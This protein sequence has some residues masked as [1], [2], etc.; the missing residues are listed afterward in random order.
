MSLLQD[1]LRRAQQGSGGSGGRTPLPGAGPLPSRRRDRRRLIR[2]AVIA[3]FLLA[4][5]LLYLNRGVPGVGTEKG[6]AP[7][8]PAEAVPAAPAE[9]SVPPPPAAS[10]PSRPAARLSHFPP[11]PEIP[12]AARETHPDRAAPSPPAVPPKEPISPPASEPE[13]PRPVVAE[14]EGT[15]PDAG[16]T[17]PQA[18]PDPRA[19][20]LERYNEGVRAQE[21]GEWDLAARIFGEVVDADPSIVEAWNG[22]GFA[23]MKRGD[24]SGAE[25]A[26]GRARRLSPEYP[27]AILNEGLLR[28]RE[29]RAAEAAALFHRAARLDPANPVPRVNLAIA[30]GLLDDLPAAERTLT[31]ARERFPRNPDIL[32]TLGVLYE[33]AGDRERSAEAYAAFLALSGSGDSGRSADVRARLRSWGVIRESPRTIP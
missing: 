17:L 31:E 13:P 16:P 9:P 7:A 32:Y 1:A 14:A 8:V 5:V 22:L 20:L 30:Q 11:A 27:A 26:I 15:P 25:E 21:R 12:A 23:R 19:R 4:V 2:A 3:L 18:P 29:G 28:V 10:A 33:R 6:P 24:L